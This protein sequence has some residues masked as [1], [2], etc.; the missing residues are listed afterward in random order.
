[1]SYPPN[2][3][4]PGTEPG[5]RDCPFSRN[6][7]SRPCCEL[8]VYRSRVRQYL[9]WLAETCMARFFDL[10]FPGQSPGVGIIGG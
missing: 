1:M 8:Y 4:A 10:A 9:A 7:A 5:P 3:P 2:F 6:L